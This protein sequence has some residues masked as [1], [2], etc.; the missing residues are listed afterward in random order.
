[1]RR[2]LSGGRADADRRTPRAVHRPSS[3]LAHGYLARSQR[4]ALKTQPSCPIDRSGELPLGAPSALI[5]EAAPR[6][7]RLRQTIRRRVALEFLLPVIAVLAAALVS[8]SLILGR[9]ISTSS[10]KPYYGMVDIL[11]EP[12]I[13]GYE[14]IAAGDGRTV[15]VWYVG[16]PLAQMQ[17]LND[18]V[19]KVAFLDGR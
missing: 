17:R 2:Q 7:S 1:M 6:W 4:V 13:T 10:G 18:A 12:Y 9:Y 11:G 3:C 19:S 5:P 16:H 14:P 8:A 15:G